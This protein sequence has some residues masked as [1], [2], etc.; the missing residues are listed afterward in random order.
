MVTSNTVG[1]SEWYDGNL[2]EEYPCLYP[3]DPIYPIDLIG[4]S[5]DGIASG[6]TTQTSTV[7]WARSNF[8]G[9]VSFEYSTTPDFS[10]IAGQAIA[11]VTNPLQPVKVEVT[12]LTAGTQYYYI[13]ADAAGA[14]ESGQFKTSAEEGN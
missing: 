8:T 9:N 6:D 5:I 11:I 14:T 7:L 2:E 10:N 12:G 13:V 3:I 1:F 4:G